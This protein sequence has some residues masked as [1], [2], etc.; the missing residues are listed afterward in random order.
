MCGSITDLQ[1]LG[2]LCGPF[3][4]QARS[5]RFTEYF[6]LAHNLWERA[7]PAKGAAGQV[8]KR[9]TSPFKSTANRD[10]SAL[11]ALV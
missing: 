6:R 10:N 5:H 3:A 8:R 11:A 4:A 2:P 7:C 1:I 9:A